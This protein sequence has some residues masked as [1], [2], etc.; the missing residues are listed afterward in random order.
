M[1]TQMTSAIPLQATALGARPTPRIALI[2]PLRDE[3]GYIEA[4]IESIV[5]QTVRPSKWLIVDDGS[6]DKTP[7]IVRRYCEQVGFIELLQLPPRT[8][9]RPGGEGA[10]ASALNSIDLREFDFLARFDADLLFKSDYFERILAK[11]VENP[12]LGIAGGGLYIDRNG[13][14]IPELAPEYHVRGALKM[15]RRECFNELGGL[16][17]HIGWDTID[18]VSAWSHGWKTRSFMEIRV[19]HRRPTGEGIQAARIY[20]ERGRAEY[21]TWSHPVFVTLKAAR[22]ARTNLRNAISFMSGF[23][24][25]YRQ[26]QTRLQSPAFRRTRRRQQIHRMFSS[27]LPQTLRRPFEKDGGL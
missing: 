15:Y 21:L 14:M 20:R 12:R 5:A 18:E 7:V 27:I 17:T 10:I 19:I 24:S 23:L 25:C 11:F 1:I 13:S 22:M 8:E 4:M 16:A 2:T 9:R 3:E 6:T 26:G